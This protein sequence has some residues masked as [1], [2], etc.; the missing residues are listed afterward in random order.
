MHWTSVR[1]WALIKD[2]HISP[3]FILQVCFTQD[4]FKSAWDNTG[5]YIKLRP[6]PPPL[7]LNDSRNFFFLSQKSYFFLYGKPFTPSLNGIAIK[8]N[9][10]FVAFLTKDAFKSAWDNEFINIFRGK[11]INV[12]ALKLIIKNCV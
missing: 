12:C 4:A 1:K 9:I 3:I 10:F 7:E 6:S 8:I 2:Q 11:Y 5:K